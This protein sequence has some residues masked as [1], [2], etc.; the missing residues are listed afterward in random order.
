[1]SVK[2]LMSDIAIRI[3]LMITM[4]TSITMSIDADPCPGAS[5]ASSSSPRS[6]SPLAGCPSF[7]VSAFYMY[8]TMN[9]TMN[10]IL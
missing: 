10:T 9:A 7:G 6:P 4:H 1:M 3:S 5:L 2:C 8:A